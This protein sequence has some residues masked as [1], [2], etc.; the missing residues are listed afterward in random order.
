MLESAGQ[1]VQVY[2]CGSDDDDESNDDDEN[3]DGDESDDSE[4]RDPNDESDA[5]NRSDDDDDESD[6]CDYTYILLQ[7][8][9]LSAASSGHLSRFANAR[10]RGG[11][12]RPRCRS[13][14]ILHRWRHFVAEVILVSGV[15][16]CRRRHRHTRR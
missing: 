10:E 13:S 3:D 11:Y 7:G 9:H 14:T 15:T 12:S 2:L 5:S 1:R 6:V 8:P 16:R 4:E